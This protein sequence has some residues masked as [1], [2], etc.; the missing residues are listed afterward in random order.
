MFKRHQKDGK[1]QNSSLKQKTDQRAKD[2][3]MQKSK[4]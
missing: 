2:D 1:Q 3:K 4:K